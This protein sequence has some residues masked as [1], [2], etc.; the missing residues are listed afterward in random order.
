MTLPYPKSEL[1]AVVPPARFRPQL[2]ALRAIAVSSVLVSHLLV[3]NG[4]AHH[5]VRL[6]FVISGFLIT[7]I[8]L[9]QR[10]SEAQSFWQK[11]QT[12]YVRR[13][14]RI[15][16]TYYLVLLVAALLGLENVRQ[17]LGW[18]L[19]YLS[20]FYYLLKGR[21]DPTITGHLWSL[22]VEEQF[23]LV[24]PFVIL[25]FPRLRLVWLLAGV[26]G[27]AV[28]Y[29][30]AVSPLNLALPDIATPAAF[31]ALGMGAAL[32][33]A[34]HAGASD[35]ALKR[36]LVPAGALSA[37][38]LLLSTS[39]PAAF[40]FVTG[41][42]F[43]AVIFTGVVAAAD[44]GIGGLPKRLL[45]WAPVLYIGKISYG[46]YLYHLF[47]VYVIWAV[48]LRLGIDM[49]RR[50]LAMFLVG[51]VLTVATATGSWFLIEKPLAGLKRRYSYTAR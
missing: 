49:P 22:S 14:I 48:T 6:F 24:W 50:G 15:W 4:A 41:D 37:V 17:S 31:D 33:L 20:N 40:C 39:A 36:F 13:S 3:P 2:D 25:L 7:G 43:F 44:A 1:H 26:I 10:D 18:H 47:V 29:R 11:A 9:R 19:A 5:G 51:T 35:V 46:I 28:V 21:W 38:A 42:F 30:A 34:K 32:A 23:Y 16:P 27:S 45:E 8:L 12:F